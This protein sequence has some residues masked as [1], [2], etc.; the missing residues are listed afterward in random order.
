M[1]F[2]EISYLIEENV[3]IAFKV[4]VFDITRVISESV[5]ISDITKSYQN[6]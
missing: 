5:P 1:G 6:L 3:K 2:R 4:R